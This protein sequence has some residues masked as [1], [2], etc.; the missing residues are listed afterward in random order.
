MTFETNAP[1][2]KYFKQET[3]PPKRPASPPHEYVLADNPDIAVSLTELLP[4]GL[5]NLDAFLCS[6]T[7][8]ANEWWNM[9]FL[10]M[11]RARFSDAFPKSLP[12]YGPQD[13]ERGVQE[14]V[15]GEHAE[16]LLCA[17]LGLVLNR[18][19]DVEYEVLPLNNGGRRLSS[20]LLAFR[21]PQ[22]PC[23][24]NSMLMVVLY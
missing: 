23:C 19:K 7:R 21:N 2:T 20:L 11:F 3:P 17:L 12:H 15:P 5:E 24:S 6:V 10:V 9:Q 16:R 1:I 18:K 8:H 13:I 14:T 4:Y 22:M